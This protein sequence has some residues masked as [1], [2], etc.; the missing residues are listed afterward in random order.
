MLEA[1]DK[2]RESVRLEMYIFRAD[3]V[4]EQFRQ[5]LVGA[6]QRGLKV[7]VLIDAL[8]SYPLAD[9]FW[10]VFRASGGQFR[11]FN[12]IIP[13]RFSIRDHRKILVCDQA[14]AFIGGFNLAS[15]YRGDGVKSGWR[16][17]GLK[18]G[19]KLARE[20]AA[21]FDDMFEC[22][23]FRHRPFTRL[24]KSIRQKTVTAPEAK[25]L[26][27]GPSRNNPIKRALRAD[28]KEAL[29]VQ[30]MSPYFLPPWRIRRQLLQAAARPGAKVQI[31]VP[32]R[33]DVPLTQLAAQSFYRRLLLG[34]VEIYEYQPQILHAKLFVID[35][36]VY[37]G[38]TNLDSRS[39]S[40]NYEL[41][42]RLTNPKRE[43][44]GREIF[45]EALGHCRRVDLADWRKSRSL[46]DRIKA[47]LAY[48]LLARVD[49]FI[50]DQ[51]WRRLGFK[52]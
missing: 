41:M 49:P 33:S 40:I 16:D 18:V 35:S 22:A 29:Q 7:W 52:K 28:L 39:L 38:S 17:L 13:H 30:I 19:G 32:G 11:R 8:G 14:V 34:G 24:R 37:V 23:A 25:L 43:Q 31:I 46:W 15:A 2:A 20:L 6:R 50:A 4:G 5:A 36:V 27:G 26:L 47:R 44:E 1:I 21:A 10:K 48:L 45:Q 12:P 9:S 42:V 3:P 51:Q